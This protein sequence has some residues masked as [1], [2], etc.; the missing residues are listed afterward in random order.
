METNISKKPE[1]LRP[2]SN[3]KPLIIRELDGT[4]IIAKEQSIHKSFLNHDFRH[5]GLDHNGLK[6]KPTPVQIHEMIK[7]SSGK[8]LFA[9]LP[10]AWNQKWLTQH[11]VIEFCESFKEWL[12]QNEHATMFLVKINENLPIDENK[13]EE[14]LVMVHTF[15][16]S[17][18]LEIDV[19][20]FE[21]ARPWSVNGKNNY[22]LVTP[23]IKQK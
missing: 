2:I 12:K 19:F 11:Q 23:E 3:D 8:D 21:P 15:V 1:L 9:A 10:G 7:K 16:C 20:R 4:R 6:T 13:P 5:W 14:N 22:R 18:G 17:H